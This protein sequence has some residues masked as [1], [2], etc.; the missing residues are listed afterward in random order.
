MYFTI[1]TIGNFIILV[2]L[3]GVLATWL[4]FVMNERD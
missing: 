3:I 2:G 4:V 1:L